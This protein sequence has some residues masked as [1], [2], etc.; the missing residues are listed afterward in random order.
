MVRHHREN[1]RLPPNRLH[2]PKQLKRISDRSRER[3]HGKDPQNKHS[4]DYNTYAERKCQQ[5]NSGHHDD[6]PPLPLL[7]PPR[8]SAPV[9]R[10]TL[11]GTRTDAG[12][13][14]STPV[15][16]KST[17][18]RPLPPV[19]PQHFR[20]KL[21]ISKD[22]RILGSLSAQRRPIPTG[23]NTLFRTWDGPSDPAA[24]VSTASPRASAPASLSCA[25]KC[26]SPQPGHESR[27]AKRHSL[28]PCAAQHHEG[29][30]G[31]SLS[32]RVSPSFTSRPYGG[33]RF[34]CGKAGTEIPKSRLKLDSAI[35]R[36]DGGRST[37]FPI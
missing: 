25:S 16:D 23:S 15:P 19:C 6:G 22:A 34:E 9:L 14:P 30:A 2:N 20:E 3:H 32:A 35:P 10:I 37:L 33:G 17:A 26:R 21:L 27:R 1:K 11:V 7:P 29:C 28:T 18:A 31:T 12:Q 36:N 8:G 5:P 4:D 13:A 24:L